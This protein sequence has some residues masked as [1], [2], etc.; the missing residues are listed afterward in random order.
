ME[1]TFENGHTYV[2]I[3]GIA[4]W[5]KNPRYIKEDAFERLK[6]QIVDFGHYKPLLVTKDGT[7]IGG[8]MRYRAMSFLNENIFHRTLPDGTTRE[9][10][11]RGRFNKVWITELDFE[12]EPV[13]PGQAAIVYPVVDGVVNKERAFS[14]ADHIMT[15]YALSDNDNVGRY[16]NEALAMLVQ[17]F[18]EL[19][20]EGLFEIE[21]AAPVPLE[22]ILDDFQPDG[23]DPTEDELPPEPAKEKK[24]KLVFEFESEEEMANIKAQLED[25]KK[26]QGTESSAEVLEFL[27]KS[28]FDPL[29]MDGQEIPSLQE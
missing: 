4:P 8:N 16:D 15:E 24:H 2:S 6:A 19:I 28:Y 17:P 20:P 1:K 21:V 23:T 5:D 9:H 7:I 3:K 29:A 26:D 10:D 18:Q 14:S 12:Y 13:A 27:I 22:S 11:L 25:L